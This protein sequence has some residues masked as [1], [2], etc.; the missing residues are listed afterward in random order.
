M[1]CARGVCGQERTL[2]LLFVSS[3]GSAMKSVS[4]SSAF[5]KMMYKMMCTV[6]GENEAQRFLNSH[7]CR[8]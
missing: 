5:Y 3:N 2:D 7:L 8:Y 6:V 4:L 1:D